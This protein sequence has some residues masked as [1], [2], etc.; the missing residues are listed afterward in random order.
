ME[1]Q[2]TDVDREVEQLR[3]ELWEEQEIGGGQKNRNYE[4]G[5]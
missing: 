2:G 4:G 5:Q 1:A 3:K